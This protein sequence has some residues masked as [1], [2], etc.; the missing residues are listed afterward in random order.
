[1]RSL[2]LSGLISIGLLASSALT[3]PAAGQAD[4]PP[5]DREVPIEEA[6]LDLLEAGD[7]ELEDG[8]PVERVL[9]PPRKVS[10]AP[11]TVEVYGKR[12][13]SFTNEGAARV[14]SDWLTNSLIELGVF[15]VVN[16]ERIRAVLSERNLEATGV[17]VDVS[18]EIS[19][20]A[21]A[22]AAKL[23]KVN[24]IVLG[25]VKNLGQNSEIDFKLLDVE[26]GTYESSFR[27]NFEVP[28]NPAI[29][30]VKPLVERIVGQLAE[31]FPVVADVQELLP[32]GR[33]VV[34]AGT[35]DGI[36]VGHQVELRPIGVGGAS[37]SGTVVA[38]GPLFSEVD[39]ERPILGFDP[40]RYQARIKIVPRAEALL[41]EGLAA[42]RQGRFEEAVETFKAGIA[43]SPNHTDLN[44]YLARSQWHLRQYE[45]ALGSF[46]ATL[47]LAPNDQKLL[48]DALLAM[49]EGG[50]Y[51]QLLDEIGKKRDSTTSV[52]TTLLAGQS[53]EALGY[54]RRARALYKDAFRL[55]PGD[56][57]IHLRL[58][59]LAAR[60]G[61][62]DE[63]ARELG[64]GEQSGGTSLELRL[65]S[66]ALAGLEG[67]PNDLLASLAG[68][69]AEA[70]NNDGFGAVVTAGQVLLADSAFW[71]ASLELA[72]SGL[73]INPRYVG[74]VL[75]AAEAS[76]AGG[77]AEGALDRLEDALAADPNNVALLVLEGEVLAAAGRHAVAEQRLLQAKD[78]AP[79]QW[80]ATD[81]LGDLY[82]AQ[83]EY[84]RAISSY[85]GS[86]ETAEAVGAGEMDQ[87]LFKLGKTAVLADQYA[88]ATPY[89]ERCVDERPDHEECRYF[90]GLCYF[91]SDKRQDD[92]RAIVHLKAAAGVA[93]ESAYYLGALYDRLEQFET[94]RGWYGR[95]VDQGCD[96]RGASQRRIDEI[97]SIVGT[98]VGLRGAKKELV[99][100]DVGRIHGV[101]PGKT[102]VVVDGGRVTGS[103]RVDAVQE[104]TSEAT[105]LKGDPLIGQRVRFR[106]SRPKNLIA[107]KAAKK[108][109]E[110]KWRRAP[111]PEIAFYLVEHSS[112]STGPWREKKK[113]TSASYVDKSAKGGQDH[114][115]RIKAVTSRKVESPQSEIVKIRLE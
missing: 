49:F 7:E 83:G 46:R 44:A 107:N 48:E 34:R 99:S 101:V 41:A 15:N 36:E 37:G 35:E 24:F 1:M 22:S 40:F 5:G 89:L 16:R 51:L 26:T 29:E 12:Y 8:E 47:A 42:Y 9:A 53:Y 14:L 39:L 65:A 72:E 73:E 19:E 60:T 98:V 57:A 11:W 63:A 92:E 90:L 6:D 91:Q 3:V 59:V 58:G 94:A 113:V 55:E 13:D 50:Q 114:Y 31:G 25:N 115:Y 43:E 93:P 45:S 17:A 67:D 111:E 68:L 78:L 10:I 110:L 61:N 52:A 88:T 30:K 66:R 20:S 108:G 95:C 84:L 82:Y 32:D 77:D 69:L 75:L 23:L 85:Q 105:L 102:A 97:E 80:R 104:R 96:Q 70:R 54:P 71:Q 112:K 33:V 38:A 62:V 21:L 86:L 87:R 76:A 81:A 27:L 18:Q 28:F 109:V 100:L 106:P 4:A 56:P 2:L 74:G 79:E 103:I 64:L